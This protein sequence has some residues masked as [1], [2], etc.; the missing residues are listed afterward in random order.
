MN[1]F[2]TWATGRR[3]AIAGSL[4]SDMRGVVAA[5]EGT[6]MRVAQASY[7]QTVDWASQAADEY[8]ACCAASQLP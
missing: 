3:M 4:A 8:R 6:C 2:R 1:R 7:E 5:S